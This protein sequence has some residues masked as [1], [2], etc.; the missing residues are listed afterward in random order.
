M[1]GQTH[2]IFDQV[3]TSSPY[4]IAG[5]LRAIAVA[6][7]KRSATLASVPTMEEAGVRGFEASTYTGVFLPSATPRDIVKRVYDALLKV[8]DQP[9]TREAFNRLG[10]EVIK[11][12][13]E[14][15]TRRISNDLA[16][17]KKVQ[18]QTGIMLD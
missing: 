11:S 5:K 9:A 14:E 10:A 12:T 2:C 17:W 15:L 7:A 1:S 6:S 3:S 18:Q 4:V 8:L 16:K 13:P